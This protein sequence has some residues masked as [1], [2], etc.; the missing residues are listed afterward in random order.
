MKKSNNN[1]YIIY[2]GILKL[3]EENIF[4]SKNRAFLYGD[5]FFETIF[6]FNNQIPFLEFHLERLNKAIK[7]LHLISNDL[8]KDREALKNII[9]Y[10]ARKNKLYKRY[11]VRI[12]IFRNSGGYFRANDNSFSYTIH[13]YSLPDDNFKLNDKGLIIGVYPDIKKNYS[14][15][16]Q[17]KTLNSLSNVLAANYSFMN[18]FDD[19]IILNYLGNIVETSNSNIFF[20]SKNKIFTPKIEDGCVAGIMRHLIITTLKQKG[21]TVIEESIPLSFLDDT[22]EIFISNAISGIRFVSV[23]QTKRFVNFLTRKIHSQLDILD[24]F[25]K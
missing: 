6:A 19:V 7:T 20:V 16:S 14:P 23:F 22:D 17:F 21:I 25:I 9:T 1:T 11:R 12:T 13:T 5:G 10:L 2:N 4:S 3:E 18:N 24:N 15:L 8:F